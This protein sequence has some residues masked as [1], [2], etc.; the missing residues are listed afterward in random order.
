MPCIYIYNITYV[1]IYII[2]YIHIIKIYHMTKAQAI[3]DKQHATSLFD[4]F[5]TIPETCLD[6]VYWTTA[7]TPSI[8]AQLARSF[9]SSN[10]LNGWRI[11][12]ANKHLVMEIVDITGRWPKWIPLFF[13]I[14]EVL[15]PGQC[16]PQCKMSHHPLACGHLAQRLALVQLF[17]CCVVCYHLGPQ[18]LCQNP[19]PVHEKPLV[20]HMKPLLWSNSIQEVI[21]V[22]ITPRA[23][24]AGARGRA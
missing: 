8:L 21:P 3:N 13:F 12:P 22:H 2:I 11:C 18:A 1:Y 10:Q 23:W 19:G 7:V 15:N 4:V 16:V 6:P 9:K 5:F 14:R 24:R 17:L 20:M